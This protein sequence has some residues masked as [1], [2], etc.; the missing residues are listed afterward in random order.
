[1]WRKYQREIYED[2]TTGIVVLHWARQIGKSFTLAAWAVRRLLDHPGRL[3]TVLSNSRENG[4]EFVAKCA[5][6]CR[7]AGLPYAK[8]DRSA[9]LAYAD[10]RMEVRIRVEGKTGRIKVL[11][12][13]PR[14]ARGFSGDLILDEFAFHEDAEAI[15]A[16]AEPILASNKDFLCRIA[17]TGNGRHNLFY[18]MVEGE[19]T[20]KGETE[21]PNIEHSTSN[22]KAAT[23][24]EEK[25]S[26]EGTER[27]ELENREPREIHEQ[28]GERNLTTESLQTAKRG[29]T[30][31]GDERIEQKP[32][33]ETEPAQGDA[34]PL[35]ISEGDEFFSNLWN[36]NRQGN[37]R[38]GN[39]DTET[40]LTA[41]G[42][43]LTQMGDGEIEQKVT[44]ETER[45]AVGGTPT[46]AT[47]TVA[48]PGTKG[49]KGTERDAVGMF[50]SREGFL[51]SR[52]SRTM[53]NRMGVQIY[54]A[55]TREAITPERAR[56]QAL[57]KRSYDQNYECAFA[58]E[59]LSLLSHELISAAEDDTA[60]II[61]EENWNASALA[62]M[63]EAKHDLYV[64]FDVGR[65]VDLSVITVLEKVEGKFW[66][67]GILRIQDM[68]LPD[69]EL[70]LGEICR[71]PKFRA[72]AIDMTGLGLG[73]YEYA[74]KSFGSRIRG[75]NFASTVPVTKAI[76]SEGR[77]RETARVTETM[78][79]ELLRCYEDRRL[80][81]PRDGRLRD[82]LR[83]PEK[84]TSPGG[85]VSISATRD[86]AG[87]AD[88]FWSLALAVEAGKGGGGKGGIELIKRYKGYLL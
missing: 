30:R 66:A 63:R 26:Q 86:E 15:W 58:D 4:A 88:H 53:A 17:S 3:V 52:I 9:S 43:G 68:R 14:T 20:R 44:E 61:C 57:D 64:G 82:D 23:D 11:A 45:D 13:N 8:R 51:V 81:H 10:L 49:T 32:T 70:R 36:R 87:H 71:L 56:A 74:R 85:R 73:L 35:Q 76:V 5:E 22:G 18:R 24:G 2:H 62:N 21:T 28:D 50:R 55:Q 12:A 60:G 47:E 83:K 6:I 78:A 84:V 31:M 67:R 7:L 69:Q 41:D 38:Q 80:K 16:A 59:N 19:E 34:I 1:M 75:I 79:M 48:L 72:A 46:A 40:Y 27:T 65:K 29:C 37:E 39:G 42:R 25:I 77:K 33:K 54:D